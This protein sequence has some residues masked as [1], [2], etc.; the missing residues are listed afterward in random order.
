[1]RV[2]IIGGNGDLGRAMYKCASSS[3]QIRIIDQAPTPKDAGADYRQADILDLPALTE[4]LR[5]MDAVIH[6]A[7]LR[8]PHLAPPE[9]VFRVNAHG[10][11]HVTLACEVLGIPQIVYASSICYYGYL[12]RAKLVSPPYFPI[13]ENTP[14]YTEDSYSLSKRV[15][16]EIMKAFVQRTNGAVA[17]MRYAYLSGV[18]VGG[19]PFGENHAHD[20]ALNEHAAKTWWS[21]VYV[22]DAAVVTWRALDYIGGR[23]NLHEAFNIGADDTHTLAPTR[24]LLARFFAD[25]DP[26]YPN[27]LEPDSH[28]ALFSNARARRILGFHPTPSTWRAQD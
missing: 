15:G 18:A 28:A 13:D 8:S 7:A 27:P 2:A 17:S 6:L 1:M 23:S 10:A 26:C 4:A 25:A 16:E 11:Y 9:T 21:Y 3:H 24:E 22:Q 5:G 20:L 12:F 19:A 14:S